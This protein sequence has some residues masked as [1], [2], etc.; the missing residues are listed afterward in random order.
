MWLLVS[1]WCQLMFIVNAE[2]LHRSDFFKPQ[3][4]K[5]SLQK[6]FNTRLL[7]LSLNGI[8]TVH[9]VGLNMNIDGLNIN[10]ALE[11]W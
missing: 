4:Q 3:C 2:M 8:K 11:L 9:I 7:F 1:P 6:D 5:W 10:R